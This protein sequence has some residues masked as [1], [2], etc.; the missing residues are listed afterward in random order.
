MSSSIANEVK[1]RLFCLAKAVCLLFPW[2]IGQ[3]LGGPRQQYYIAYFLYHFESAGLISRHNDSNRIVAD[4]DHLQSVE[5]PNEGYKAYSTFAPLACAASLTAARN[6]RRFMRHSILTQEKSDHA[7]GFCSWYIR[8]YC[9]KMTSL[10]LSAV[11]RKFPRETRY[12]RDG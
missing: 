10:F 12:T 1:E 2:I 8:I 9:P 3:G 6:A 11:Y 5:N 4:K 7:V